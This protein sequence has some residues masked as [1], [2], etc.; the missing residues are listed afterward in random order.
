[1]VKVFGLKKDDDP[2]E[3][4]EIEDDNSSESSDD[5]DMWEFFLSICLAVLVCSL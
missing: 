1:M 4:V 3:E 5:E 2:G